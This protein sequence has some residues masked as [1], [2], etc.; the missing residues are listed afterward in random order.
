[1]LLAV[2]IAVTLIGFY[3]ALLV[4]LYHPG[5]DGQVRAWNY[6]ETLVYRDGESWAIRDERDKRG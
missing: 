4:G 5:A 1:M 2:I 3:V 6:P